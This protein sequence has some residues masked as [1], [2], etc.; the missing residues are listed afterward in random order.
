MNEKFKNLSELVGKH[1]K[2]KENVKS[3]GK[4]EEKFFRDYF[5]N[6]GHNNYFFCKKNSCKKLY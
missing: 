4:K 6:F 5:F 1:G 3:L 2:I